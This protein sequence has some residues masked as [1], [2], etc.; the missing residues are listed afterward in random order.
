MELM[1]VLHRKKA[2]QRW[3]RNTGLWLLE[4]PFLAAGGTN[5]IVAPP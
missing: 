4:S 5:D 1:L 2:V 3:K